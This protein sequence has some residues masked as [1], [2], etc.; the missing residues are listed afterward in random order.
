MKIRNAGREETI[1]LQMT[2]MIDIVFQLLVFFVMTFK[3]VVPEGD[4]NIKMPQ[5][6]PQKGPPSDELPPMTVKLR[7]G[8][9]GHLVDIRLNERNLGD[10]FGALRST[11]IGLVGDESGPGGEGVTAE[12][13]IDSDYHLK[14][15]YTMRAVTAISGHIDE[16]SQTVIKLIEKIRFAPPTRPQ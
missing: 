14:W 13:E 8:D 3:I 11:I 7:A 10:D 4:F 6:S 12:I 9:D 16:Q 15:E 2:P 5:A 1:R